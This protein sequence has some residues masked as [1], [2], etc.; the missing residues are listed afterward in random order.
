MLKVHGVCKKIEKSE[1]LKNISLD[2]GGNSLVAIL[3]PS[4]GGKTTL[5]RLIMGFESPDA[6]D[7]LWNEKLLSTANSVVISP[8]KRNFGMVF[9]DSLLFPHLNVTENIKFGLHKLSKKEQENRASELIEYFHLENICKRDVGNLSGGEVQ[10]VALARSL[11][12][13]PLL[14]L[15]DEPFSNVDKLIRL[16]LV[17][18]LRKWVLST[19]ITMVMVTHDARDALDLAEN[20]LIISQGTLVQQGNIHEVIN[21]PVNEWVEK[22]L[23]AGLG[24]HA[25]HA[26]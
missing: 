1:L 22:F 17:S 5:L 23:E 11:A 14:L 4:G 2:I 25:Q 19:Q 9:Q 15:L 6:G 7:I 12:P 24:N 3:G 18:L 13:K 10:R 20:I 21:K 8:E 16:E 26:A